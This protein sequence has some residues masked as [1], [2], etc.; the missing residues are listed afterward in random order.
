MKCVLEIL[1]ESGIRNDEIDSVHTHAT[2]TP[3][4]DGAEA[5]FLKILFGSNYEKL[6]K[7]KLQDII[8]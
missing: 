1:K 5:Q 2:A 3:A 6:M 8:S 4:G 7:A